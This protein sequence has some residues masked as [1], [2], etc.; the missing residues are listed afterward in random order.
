[1]DLTYSWISEQT[2]VVT[3]FYKRDLVENVEAG[4]LFKS[5]SSQKFQG[6]PW[7]YYRN[8]PKKHL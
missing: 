4:W 7:E 3:R 8:L 5:N 2:A 1:M 6:I